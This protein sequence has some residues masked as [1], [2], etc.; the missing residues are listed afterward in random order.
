MAD[1]WE[2]HHPQDQVEREKMR[3]ENIG[4]RLLSTQDQFAENVTVEVLGDFV[5]TIEAVTNTCAET[6]P[7]DGEILLQIELTKG[8]NAEYSMTF[9]GNLNPEFLQELYDNL[10]PLKGPELK[11]SNVSFQIN[12]KVSAIVR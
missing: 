3:V 9:Q 5:K 11:K 12:F 6:Y 10:S 8:K 1:K 4:I 7:E 2:T